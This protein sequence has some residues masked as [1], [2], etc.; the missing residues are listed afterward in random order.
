[1]TAEVFGAYATPI[2]ICDKVEN[3]NT[4]QREITKSYDEVEW[5][6]NDDWGF[7]HYL[8]QPGLEGNIVPKIKSLENTIHYH[9]KEYINQIGFGNSPYFLPDLKYRIA[10]SWFAKFDKHCYAHVHNHGHA[11]ISGAYYF[12]VP[13]N[14]GEFF[15][16]GTVPQFDQ[17]LLFHHLGCRNYFSTQEGTLILMPGFMNHG[18]RT[19]M[20]DETRCSVA[21]NIIFERRDVEEP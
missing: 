12:K 17:S 10:R 7:T 13:E 14:A 3:F 11:D 6:S 15:V 18:V 5:Y 21:F 4:I 2:Y 20:I 19:T 16:T 9:L 8:S 1:M